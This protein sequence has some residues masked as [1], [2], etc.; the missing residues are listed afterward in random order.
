MKINNSL[1]HLDKI[2]KKEKNASIAILT[3]TNFLNYNELIYIIKTVYNLLNAIK[4][5]IIIN[6]GSTP[7]GTIQFVDNLAKFNKTQYTCMLNNE[8]YLK[9]TLNQKV[10]YE[11]INDI[12]DSIAI[13]KQRGNG[14]LEEVHHYNTDNMNTL[15]LNT[16]ELNK[17]GKRTK[18]SI[19][20]NSTYKKWNL[21][22]DN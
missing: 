13:K 4:N 19:K 16:K 18:S 10:M 11:S 21:S 15:D 17:N 2:I 1:N 14:I 5:E 3:S 22:S 6:N 9:Q 20:A 8:K 7:I 12:N